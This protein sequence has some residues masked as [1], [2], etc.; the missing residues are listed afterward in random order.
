M[1]EHRSALAHR[2]A[3]EW[4]VAKVADTSTLVVDSETCGKEHDAGLVDLAIIT[5]AGEVL[6][7]SL[8]NPGHDIPADST[9]VH[10]ISDADVS[11]AP[12]WAHVYSAVSAILTERTV[13]AYNSPFDSG[14]IAAECR[15]AD[16]PFIKANWEDVL[17]AFS[18]WEGAPGRFPGS[19]RWWKL[20]EAA[21]KFGVKPGGHR[22]VSDAE[23]A[24]LVVL[25]MARGG[26]ASSER[27]LNAAEPARASPVAAAQSTLFDLPDPRR[28]TR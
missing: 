14:V 21:A 15:M 20:D 27:L 11:G 6:F 16:L 4:A 10:G 18:D 2:K 26:L 25:G 1:K 7:D 5:I 28:Y 24:R 3:T 8:I 23:T 19:F 9:A 22:A 13:L 12:R 17:Q